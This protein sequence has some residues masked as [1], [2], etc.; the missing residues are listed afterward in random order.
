MRSDG[1]LA[2]KTIRNI[3]GAL[4]TLFR[5]AL[6]EELVT[7]DPC[8]LPRGALPS[9]REMSPSATRRKPSVSALPLGAL[10]VATQYRDERLKTKTPRVVPVHPVLAELLTAWKCSGFKQF[11]LREPRPEDFIVPSRTWRCRMSGASHKGLQ[12]DCMVALVRAALA[13]G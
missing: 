10:S 8:V 2:P 6:L 12:D 4:R 13:R 7:S 11:F 5:D 1:R 9:P 3:Y